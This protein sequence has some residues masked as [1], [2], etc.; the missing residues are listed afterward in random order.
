[1]QVFIN[2]QKKELAGNSFDALISVLELKSLN[3]I[4][5]AINDRVVSKKDWTS[6]ALKE[7]DRV[8][9]IRATQGG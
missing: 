4:A 9:L 5:L 8:T 7:N 1:M 3:G 6:I 2:S